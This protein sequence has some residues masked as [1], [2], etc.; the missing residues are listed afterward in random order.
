MALMN[1][2]WFKPRQYGYGVTPVTWE[3][4]AL[5]VV[6]M[7]VVV[8]TSMLA[9]LFA[10]GN[11]W[12]IVAFTIDALAIAAFILISKSKTEGAWRWRWGGDR[13]G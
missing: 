10:R 8:M 5:T 4:W 6:T 9:P 13:G 3:G 2:Y 1:M 11:S 12:G 7:F